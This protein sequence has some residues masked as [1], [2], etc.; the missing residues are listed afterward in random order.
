MIDF[1]DEESSYIRSLALNCL[2]FPAG[3]VKIGKI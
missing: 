1:N 3:L 2:A